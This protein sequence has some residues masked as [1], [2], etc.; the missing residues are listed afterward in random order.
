MS[1]ESP[2]YVIGGTLPQTAECYVERSADAELFEGVR[3]GDYVYVLDAR[4]MGKSSLSVRA[5]KHLS[6]IGVRA[7]LLDLT[8]YGVRNLTPEQW[9]AA[10]L[11][12]LGR[13]LGISAPLTDYWKSSAGDAPVQ[14]FFGA[15]RDVAL[16]EIGGPIAIF[17]DEIDI[18][19]SLPFDTDEFFISIRQCFV[20]RANEERLKRLSFV[21]FGTAAPTELIQDTRISPFNIGRRV[22]LNDFSLEEASVLSRFLPGNRND[23]LRRILHWTGG[24]PYLTQRM[25]QSIAGA[26]TGFK[27]DQVCRDLFFESGNTESDNNL[28]FVR[29]RLL[30]S[31]VDLLSLLDLYGEVRA[32][33]RVPDS[34]SNPLCTVLKMSGIVRERGG[35]LHIRN[36]IYA[37]VFDRR[38]IAEQLPDAEVRRQQAAFRRGV[39]RAGLVASSLVI[40]FAAIAGYAVNE[41]R[42]EHDALVRAKV[43]TTK[44]ADMKN[45]VS[46]VTSKYEADYIRQLDMKM[47]YLSRDLR[48]AKKEAADKAAELKRLRALPVSNPAAS[49]RPHL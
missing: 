5:L 10:L 32:G 4:Q 38:W 21:L 19:R 9:Y 23:V 44:M 27:V 13:G 48:R 47:W 3:L 15:L 29:N 17:I 39:W 20:G 43:V 46:P 18:T 12:D 8:K 31:D 7:A 30:R 2:F 14:R 1:S 26:G 36:R 41:A 45:A 6:E 24:H 35:F 34:V 42:L 49:S 25:C 16:E 22:D 37:K 33:K 28:A 11:R 40:A